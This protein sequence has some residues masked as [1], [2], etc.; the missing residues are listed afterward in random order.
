ML[1]KFISL[2]VS[3]ENTAILCCVGLWMQVG[4]RDASLHADSLPPL[5][6]P[7]LPP[8]YTQRKPSALPALS[9]T[10]SVYSCR[11]LWVLCSLWWLSPHTWHSK[12]P[13]PSPPSIPYTSASYSHRQ[14]PTVTF[15]SSHCSRNSCSGSRPRPPQSTNQI[16]GDPHPLVGEQSRVPLSSTAPGQAAGAA[17]DSLTEDKVCSLSLPPGRPHP[18]VCAGPTSAPDSSTQQ[19][20]KKPNRYKD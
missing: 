1:K 9:T 10:T 5:P 11:M 2:A 4:H 16:T 13:L 15:P 6:L 14:W 20:S 3:L 7:P 12:W 17:L 19:N 8:S 18:V